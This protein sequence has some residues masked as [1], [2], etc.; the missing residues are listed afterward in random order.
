MPFDKLLSPIDL[1]FTT[2]KNRVIMGSMHTGLEEE[3]DGFE[4]LAAFYGARARGGVGLIITGGISP[5]FFG[6]LAP[7][8][9]EMSR[10]KHVREH[11]KITDAVHA[12]GGKICMQI[13]HAGRYAHHP[14]ALA[15]SAVKSPINR[16]TP[17]AM[18]FWTVSNTIRRFVRAAKLAKEAG[19]DGVEVMG[20]E[21]YLINQFL[22]KRTNQRRDEWGR[23]FDNSTR[24]ATSI[25]SGIRSAVG[26][27]FI[28]VYR[29]SMLDL[30]EDGQSWSEIELLA[31]RIEEAG[32][33]IINT[34]IGWHESRIPTIAQMVPRGAFSWVTAGLM[35]KLRIPLVATNRIN[36]P[37][38]AEEILQLGQADMVS[39]AR[40]FLADPD[41]I[42]KAAEGRSAHI[43]T[44][45]A[46]NQACLDFIFSRKTAT[47][48]VNPFACRETELKI[49]PAATIKHIAVV[50]SGPAGC[51]AA[52]T[53][54]KRGHR[55]V[56]FEA[57]DKL[58]GQLNLAARVSGK[59]EF[60]E[61]LRYFANELSEWRVD[62][63]LSQTFN[64]LSAPGFDAVVVATGSGPR[65][66]AL[67]GIDH[68]MVTD[69]R[70]I[71]EG[72][73]KPRNRVAII[74]TGGIGID[75]AMFVLKGSE[76]ETPQAFASRWGIDT[77]FNERGGLRRNTPTDARD[78]DR[79]IY[80][81]HR[82]KEKVGHRLG[83]TTAWIHRAELKQAKVQV[84][85]EVHYERIHDGG[86]DIRVSEKLRTLEVDQVIICA[87]Q[88]PNQELYHE[89]KS[90][91]IPTFVIGGA[92][93]AD[94]LN[95]HRAIEEGTRLGLEL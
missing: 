87:G 31:K 3:K 33:T 54:A 2:L 60:K 82:G 71:I 28:I 58:G 29:L 57:A 39:M 66:I 10:Q 43:N 68:P 55:V 64:V 76:E 92:S 35:G 51:A 91:G 48:L 49:T 27:E 44:C 63:R 89:M 83:K 6:R 59:Q 85:D 86:I 61:T 20:S 32:A 5:D 24:F 17:W 67:E 23:S 1:G 7:D 45:I 18:P 36:T 14:L 78:D 11:K 47:C 79:V 73:V 74:G 72:R 52:L 22:S 62:V 40:P 25:V 70:S 13:L 88:E 50:G 69:Y 77:A 53:L 21:G 93:R 38:L 94:E 30:V 34:G 9:A 95:A 12:S 56:L 46:C 16:F 90:L 15:P 8:S 80:M 75:T 26:R 37:E 4:K 81:L 65:S 19:Y 84:I 41:F 42:R